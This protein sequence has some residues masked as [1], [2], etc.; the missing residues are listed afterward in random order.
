VTRA[1]LLRLAAMS[2][3]GV[4]MG[5][6]FPPASL[7]PLAWVGMV[8]LLL[9]LP[10]ASAR[11]ALGLAW[12][13]TLIGAWVV[14]S[15]LPASV[16]HYFLQ[17]LALGY[18][19]FFATAT[20]MAAVYYMAWAAAH[21]ALA[22]RLDPRW[23]PLASAAAWTA[24]E[25]GRA[26]LLG[27]LGLFVGNP[28][29]LLGYSQAGTPALV[30]VASATGIYGTS[31]AVVACNVGVAVALRAAWAGDR[32]RAAQAF[33]TGLAPGALVLAFGLAA[34]RAAPLAPEPG[35]GAVP[36]AAVQGNVDVG[37]RWRSDLYGRNLDV[38]LAETRAALRAQPG[39]I[40]VWPEAAL[41][42]FLE[43][44]PLYLDAIARVLAAGRGELVVGGPRQQDAGD[45]APAYYNSVF[46]VDARGALRG[47]Y[48]KQHLV[49]FS[50]YFPLRRVDLLRRN[51]ERVRSFAHGAPTPPLPTRAGGAGVLLCNESMFPEA[52]AARVGDGAAWLV[53]PS[54][55][56][57]IPS[58][59]FA[60][61]LFDIV[62]LRAIEQ[63]RWLVR[64]STS[65]PSAIV[66]PWGRA[67]AESPPF[68][69]AHLTGWIRPLRGRT[70]YGRVGDA[71]G[72]ACLASVPVALWRARRGPARGAWRAGSAW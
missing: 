43:E 32:R 20:G 25:L 71:F 62:R 39:S 10:G 11:G 59:R 69:R 5:L 45:G 6:A 18:V 36:V 26:R 66:D 34:L 67:Q 19:F 15:W 7:R 1:S 16:A 52:A 49:P 65:G 64:A 70:V 13:F 51:F 47:R 27:A 37:T 63:R 35:P 60:D 4:A 57:W 44:E 42:F 61:H 29:G 53:V 56:G 14:G 68:A 55:D 58:R 41:T 3:S 31:F 8:P 9:A 21:R 40:V 33:A 30:Q 28:W 22:P 48:D 24:A 72:L 50:E 54:N 12:G 23:L 17:P 46:V 38:Y 2:L